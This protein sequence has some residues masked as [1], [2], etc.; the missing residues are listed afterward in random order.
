MKIV[1]SIEELIKELGIKPGDTVNIAS[2]QHEREYELEIKFIP[3]TAD[4]LNIIIQ[5]TKKSELAKMGVRPFADWTDEAYLKEGEVHFLFPG[6]WYKHLPEGF[7]VTG[8]SGEKYKFEQG[9][10][11]DDIRYGCLPY[12]FIRNEAKTVQA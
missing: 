11:D 7:E 2:S 1:N 5:H 3:Q 8:L 9:V 4:E 10:S 12:G 6:E